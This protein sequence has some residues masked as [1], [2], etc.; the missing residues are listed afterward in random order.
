MLK[1]VQALDHLLANISIN[2]DTYKNMG[3]FKVVFL[4]AFLFIVVAGKRFQVYLALIT[5]ILKDFII[6]IFTSKLFYSKLIIFVGI[7][8]KVLTMIFYN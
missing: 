6:L 4:A 5:V 3:V 2:I 7:R 8:M 1:S